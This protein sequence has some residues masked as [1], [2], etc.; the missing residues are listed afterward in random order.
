MKPVTAATMWARALIAFGVVAILS[1]CA[2]LQ[3]P[4]NSVTGSVS[5]RERIALSPDN[6]FLVVRLLDVSRA[7]APSVEIASLRQP[8]ANPPMVFILPYDLDDI[9]PKHS[10]A[11]EAKIVNA[12]G[13]LLFRNDQS[14]P[15]LTR[16]A[17][18]DVDIVVRQVP[19]VQGD[20]ARNGDGSDVPDDI[21]AIEAKLADMRVIPGQYSASDHTVTYKAYVTTDGEPLLVDEH[22]DLGD[23]GSSDVKLYYRNGQLL[24]FAEDA[25][26][27]NYGG[28]Q[29]DAP[30]HYTLTLDFA[31]GRFSSGTKTV[32]GTS[33]QPDE[34]EI[35]GALSQSKVALSRI[36]A[37]LSQLNSTP[38]PMTGPELFICDDQSRFAVTFDH[39][40]ERAIVE[41]R[42]REP[43]SL[44]QM[45]TGSGYGYGNDMYELR[46]KGADAIWTTPSGDFHCAVSS[47]PVEAAS[48]A[49]APGDFP[50]VSV[51]ELKRQGD[52]IWTRY[53]DDMMPAITA[54]LA[55]NPGDLVSVL[56]AWPMDHG[57]VGVRTINGNG[58]RYDC[59]VTSDGMGTAH[60]EQVETTTNILPGEDVVRYT[61][62]NSAYPGGECFAH[63]RL[64]QNGVF[65]GW[66]SEKTC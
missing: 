58:G 49:L 25:K 34:H 20:G 33:S 60:T 50:V 27:V 45:P 13:D 53:F 3:S 38:D 16:G 59:L 61:P 21:A 52:G 32:N 23:Y 2:A 6:T 22:R 56:K 5:Y 35:S 44:A 54:C 14:Y 30:L 43:I 29:S 11:V 57:M 41:M 66:L 37:M 17:P 28:E 24:R 19:R 39:D 10:Y 46:G 62:A 42:G 47:M 64:E 18:S 4:S 40:A 26:R 51:A 65:I 9:E 63:E 8:V 15:V 31:Q 7:D 36:E 12:N 48:L 55:K 1:G